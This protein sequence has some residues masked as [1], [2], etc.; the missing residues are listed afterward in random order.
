MSVP[1]TVNVIPESSP[2]L[3]RVIGLAV[4]ESAVYAPPEVNAPPKVSAALFPTAAAVDKPS[5]SSA[6]AV[7]TDDDFKFI[8]RK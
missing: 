2:A 3:K 4:P 7:I 5:A 6:V 8:I 1:T